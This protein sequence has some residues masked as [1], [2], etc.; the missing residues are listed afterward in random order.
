M[1]GN[2][3]RYGEPVDDP[4]SQF[5]SQNTPNVPSQVPSQTVMERFAQ[6]QQRSRAHAAPS[7]WGEPNRQPLRRQST[8][9]GNVMRRRVSQNRFVSDPNARLLQRRPVRPIRLDAPLPQFRQLRIHDVI[10]N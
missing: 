8:L 2:D 10:N 6:L 5:S 4:V 9:P 7:L 3:G 1:L